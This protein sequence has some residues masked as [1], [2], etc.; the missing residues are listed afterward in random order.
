M[1]DTDTRPKHVPPSNTFLLARDA[2]GRQIVSIHVKRSYHLLSDGR[3]V[4]EA[5]QGPLLLSGSSEDENFDEEAFNETDII[6]FKQN[7]DLIVIAHAWGK[8][9][10]SIV[11]GIS[12]GK[13]TRRYIIQGDRRVSY[14]GRGTWSFSE[15][16]PFESI[17]MCHENAYGGFDDSVPDPEPEYIIDLFDMHPGVYPRNPVGKGYVVF[18][19]RERIDGLLLPNIEHPEMLLTPENLLVS[20]P[21]QW[22]RAPLP[23]SCEW[24]DKAWYPRMVHFGAV[25][26]GIPKD[27]T[28]LPEVQKGWLDS[29][30]AEKTQSDDNA[31]D[32]H[33]GDAAAPALVLPYLRGDEMVE[34]TGLSPDGRIVVQLPGTPPKI[35]L[36]DRGNDYELQVVPHRVLISTIENGVYIVWHAAWHPPR[37]MPDVTP[38]PDDPFSKLVD[39][40]EVFVDHR[41]ISPFGQDRE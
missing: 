5:Q 39:G 7:T 27:D 11:A 19:N 20:R 12:V 26:Y 21:D 13:H 18:E 9:T 22:W 25:P 37:V 15:P 32:S 33:I 40:I 41:P 30:H 6:P 1:S 38:K 34:L 23:W 17:G 4:P 2:T 16:E 36:R 31:F 24:F 29:G 8:G 28:V 10:R 14:K 3:C 35:R